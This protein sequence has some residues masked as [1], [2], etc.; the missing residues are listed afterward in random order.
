MKRYFDAIVVVPLEEEFEV[1]LDNFHVVDDLSTA[2]H[3]RFAATPPDRK[4]TVLLVK[5]F[6]MGRTECQEAISLSLNEFDCGIAIC[7]GIAGALSS[8]LSIGDVCYSISIM[9]VLDNTKITDKAIQIAPDFYDTPRELIVPISLDR[10]SPRTKADYT[11]WAEGLGKAGA[12]LI[13]GSFS[14]KDG[15]PETIKP[16]HVLSGIIACGPVSASPAF[17]AQLKLA[18][19]KVLAIETEFG[20]LFAVARRAGVPAI[21][22][23]GISDYAGIDKNRFE[24]ETGNKARLLAATNAASFL[25]RQLSSSGLSN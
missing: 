25:V 4:T 7:V 21:T 20:G 9:D 1:V 15:K 11:A 3:I 8:D 19:R 2:T 23:R 17:N 12:Q 6:K 18:H 16:P 5:Q 24:E 22:V 14:G 10:I 13:P